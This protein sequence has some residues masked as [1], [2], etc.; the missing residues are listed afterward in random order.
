LS[1]TPGVGNSSLIPL[2]DGYDIEMERGDILQGRIGCFKISGIDRLDIVMAFIAEID[3]AG[4]F[5]LTIKIL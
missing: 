3:T 4:L 5:S 2:L 1:G